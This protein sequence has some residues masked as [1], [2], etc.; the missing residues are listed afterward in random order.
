MYTKITNPQTGKKVSIYSKGGKTLI[1]NYLKQIGGAV[2]ELDGTPLQAVHSDGNMPTFNDVR[3][4]PEQITEIQE[5]INPKL[6]W[7]SIRFLQITKGVHSTWTENSLENLSK[8]IQRYKEISSNE[9]INAF[10]I[11]GPLI[12]TY[13]DIIDK[14]SLGDRTLVRELKEQIATI[15]MDFMTGGSNSKKKRRKKRRPPPPPPPETRLSV[16]PERRGRSEQRMS[17]YVD[18]PPLNVGSELDNTERLMDI[19]ASW[20]RGA[21]EDHNNLME[22]L[23]EQLT[24]I[25]LAY[26]EEKARLESR[27][28]ELEQQE[29]DALTGAI[30]QGVDEFTSVRTARD[31][32]VQG[33]IIAPMGWAAGTGALMGVVGAG[34]TAAFGE[35]VG[36]CCDYVLN[37][38]RM[39]GGTA[40][41]VTRR[42]G[43]D[44]MSLFWTNDAPVCGWADF[45]NGRW[46]MHTGELASPF[47]G[48]GTIHQI[49]SQQICTPGRVWGE[50]CVAA[51]GT[52]TITQCAGNWP[53][54]FAG[55]MSWTTQALLASC[56]IGFGTCA[57]VGLWGCCSQ[58]SAFF[59][60]LAQ[61]RMMLPGIAIPGIGTAALL[62]AEVGSLITPNQQTYREVRDYWSGTLTAAEL[63]IRH[64][65]AATNTEREGPDMTPPRA[66]VAAGT[67]VMPVRERFNAAQ[68]GEWR[69]EE[70]RRSEAQISYRR[71]IYAINRT[72]IALKEKQ[73]A[74][75][76]ANQA[77]TALEVEA[78]TTRM[79][80]IRAEG[81]NNALRILDEVHRVETDVARLQ[82]RFQTGR[83]F[84]EHGAV[85]DVMR[86]QQLGDESAARTH[87]PSSIDMVMDLSDTLMPS[88][89]EAQTFPGLRRRK[90]GGGGT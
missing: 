23:Q 44:M 82:D 16:V 81:I 84:Q 85:E 47:Y 33:Q 9:N 22:A 51:A 45:G 68:L 5:N 11:F 65:L 79:R 41:A 6:I 90:E 38:A 57:C 59:S 73:G 89:S 18:Q 55:G 25:N 70:A 62:V 39:G 10:K 42:L 76:K 15:N 21:A 8:A 29:R 64:P 31:L 52:G 48:G 56:C 3:F 88:T 53:T 20:T 2:A 43:G 12:A 61:A 1:R 14:R 36:G 71:R 69:R 32:D 28:V 13:L 7:T 67:T 63:S 49:A 54:F 4:T 60:P 72:L 40:C 37:T 50:S 75:A 80:T 34:S 83:F 77:A 17:V 26:T 87:A 78:H 19:A 35:A 27:V 24:L 46:F 58:R 74:D 30:T 86:H 66:V